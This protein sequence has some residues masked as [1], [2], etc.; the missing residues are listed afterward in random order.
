M[1]ERI[2]KR[3]HAW[4]AHPGGALTL[5]VP[6]AVRADTILST[7]SSGSEQLRRPDLITVLLALAILVVSLAAIPFLFH[8]RKQG[9]MWRLF[10][11]LCATLIS[12][13]L[14]G[15]LS[16]AL[17]YREKLNNEEAAR[18]DYQQALQEI[19]TFP[20][21]LNVSPSN[22]RGWSWTRGEKP[23][24]TWKCTPRRP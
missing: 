6:A 8:Q 7:G 14:V 21:S 9:S 22:L 19:R 17:L 15:T 24:L 11:G 12:M 20:D 18:Q 23:W 10:T 5:L 2:L 13:A 16:L 3:I 1:N 4:P